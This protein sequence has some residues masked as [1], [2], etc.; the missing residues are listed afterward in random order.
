M[1]FDEGY[2]INGWKVITYIQLKEM[3]GLKVYHGKNF[4]QKNLYKFARDNPS[5]LYFWKCPHLPK[6][7]ETSI[8]EHK[9]KN[10]IMIR[11]VFK[12]AVMTIENGRI[13][14]V[15]HPIIITWEKVDLK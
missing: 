4:I 14:W 5:V 8:Q 13:K 2:D 1:R 10:E 12:K 11:L 7:Y 6:G 3:F 9:L 15:E